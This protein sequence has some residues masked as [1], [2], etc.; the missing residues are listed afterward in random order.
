MKDN[1]RQMT[2]C[3]KIAYV[4]DIINLGLDSE[5]VKTGTKDLIKMMKISECKLMNLKIYGNI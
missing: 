3:G 2:M 5:E 4:D 1:V